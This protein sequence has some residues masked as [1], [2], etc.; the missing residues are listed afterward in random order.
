MARSAK[1]KAT[2]DSPKWLS[3]TTRLRPRLSALVP[4]FSNFS[5]S[6]FYAHSVSASETKLQRNQF[7]ATTFE[8]APTR[9]EA[10][11]AQPTHLTGL[12]LNLLPLELLY[13]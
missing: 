5:V 12:I 1:S 3:R 8:T 2:R 13:I 7:V 4:P 10:S 6:L 9:S 11:T